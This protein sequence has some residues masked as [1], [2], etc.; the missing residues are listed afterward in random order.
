MRPRRWHNRIDAMLP[1]NK[2]FS[3]NEVLDQYIS[4]YGTK[5]APTR[6]ELTAYL[7]DWATDMRLELGADCHVYR[8]KEIV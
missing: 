2:W 7:K 6:Q 1:P 3:M 4:T 5:F 8:R